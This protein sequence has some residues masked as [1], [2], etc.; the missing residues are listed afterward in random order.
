MDYLTTL[1][2]NKEFKRVYYNAAYKTHPAVVTYLLKNK[3]SPGRYGIT[4]SK[5]IG[6]AVQRNRSKRII[7]AALTTVEKEFNFK[8]YDIVF[9]ARKDT[10]AAN[11]N[12]LT[13]V[14]RQHIKN[15]LKIINNKEKIIKKK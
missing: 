9:V 3:Y 15:L 1:K 5:K 7:T 14:I 4:T 8:N 2:L 13:S 6:N 12:L 10:P 11:S